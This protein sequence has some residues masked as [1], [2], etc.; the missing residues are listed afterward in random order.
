[1]LMT[2]PR[3]GYKA[4]K[5]SPVW[6]GLALV[7]LCLGL[8]LSQQ[9]GAWGQ[10]NVQVSLNPYRIVGTTAQE[11]RSQMNQLGPP[12]ASGRRFDAYTRWYVRWQFHY[13][14]DGQ[15][16]R[17]S[18]LQISTDITYT[19]PHWQNQSHASPALQQHWQHYYQALKRH[20]EGHANHGK[21]ATQEIWQRLSSLTQPTCNQMDIVTNRTAQAIVN[22]YAQKDQDYDRQTDH[23][24]TQGAVFP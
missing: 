11:L 15:V 13:R 17:I 1:M 22:R 18:Q 21:A 4:R 6:S 5:L 9:V 12:N 19:L 20:E 7:L 14:W 8:L 23:G 16:C 3:P 2:T 10:P 24:R